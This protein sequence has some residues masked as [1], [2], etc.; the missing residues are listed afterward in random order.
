VSTN[1]LL[2]LYP[3]SAPNVADQISYTISDSLGATATGYINIVVTNGV[4]GTNSITSITHN[5][6]SSTTVTAF[7]IPTYSYI[8]ERATNLA[9]AIWVDITTNTAT[10]N[11]IITATDSFTDLG[12]VAPAS[13]FY[14]L[15]WQP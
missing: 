10:V 15:K 1:G 9:P 12:N 5:G 3:A 4:T 2:I 14:R 6:N 13:A 8:L 11:G 7:G